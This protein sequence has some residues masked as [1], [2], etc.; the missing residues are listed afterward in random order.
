MT[1]NV[2]N[3]K[4]TKG[5]VP[6]AVKYAKDMDDNF[7]EGIAGFYRAVWAERDDGLSTKQKHLLVFA[8]ACSENN[9][10]SAIKI[11]T[12][13]KKLGVKRT[14]IEDVIMITAWT[15][16]MQNFTNLSSSLLREID[17]LG[18]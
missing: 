5:F 14:E 11:L 15:G 4:N 7:A 13:L 18:L 3:V 1:D 9:T 2:E 17:R 16:G 10:D 6:L 8:I 12:R